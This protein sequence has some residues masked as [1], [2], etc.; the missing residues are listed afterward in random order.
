MSER[1]LPCAPI[2]A[3]AWLLGALAGTSAQ[4][5]I[6]KKFGRPHIDAVS[7]DVKV[8]TDARIVDFGKVVYRGRLD[9]NPTLKRIR[10]GKASRHRNDGTNFLNREGRL[11]RKSDREY[12]R[13][14]VVEKKGLPFPGPHRLII[15]KK[16][17]VYF[18]GDH[19]KTF[20]RVR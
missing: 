19:Y 6:D 17:E 8:L 16:G 20:T 13:E 14:F 4:V 9:L 1:R 11:A 7:G 2:L 12:Y 3:L 5:K 18:T 15:G 10:E